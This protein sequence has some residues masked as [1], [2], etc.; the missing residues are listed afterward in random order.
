MYSVRQGEK[1]MSVLSL[2]PLIH[3]LLVPLLL[4]SLD[5][6]FAAPTLETYD[7]LLLLS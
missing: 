5:T 4:L 3:A 2:V 6:N 1:Q 7:F